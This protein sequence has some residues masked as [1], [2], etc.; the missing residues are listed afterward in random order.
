MKGKERWSLLDG[1]VLRRRRSAQVAIDQFLDRLVDIFDFPLA[2]P[3]HHAP[4]ASTP[5]K[6]ST[7]TAADAYMTM[8]G[9]I[10]PRSRSRECTI[11]ASKK[12]R[13]VSMADRVRELLLHSKSRARNSVICN[14][15]TKSNGTLNARE[16][17]MSWLPDTN[18]TVSEQPQDD[19]WVEHDEHDRQ[20]QCG[21]QCLADEATI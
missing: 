4:T 21:Y 12:P 15:S 2:P 19:L 11:G 17:R 10:S 8:D 20:L 7:S 14:N 13:K 6:R 18:K 16:L 3:S 1:A 9:S 5:R